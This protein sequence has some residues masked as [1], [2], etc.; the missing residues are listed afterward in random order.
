MNNN[1]E[2]LNNC[3]TFMF[4][5]KPQLLI[6]SLEPTVLIST[7]RSIFI[8]KHQIIEASLYEDELWGIFIPDG[9]ENYHHV[10]FSLLRVCQ[11]C[12]RIFWSD[13][14]DKIDF[15]TLLKGEKR[16]CED[17]LSYMYR[18]EIKEELVVT[19]AN[20]VLRDIKMDTSVLSSFVAEQRV[21]NQ[22]LEKILEKIAER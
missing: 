2:I 19:D 20:D 18:E 9:S 7:Q 12:K 22:N 21:H 1:I 8:L 5:E 3:L 10:L 13:F 15:E 11:E 4:G 16:I 17:C 14:K 6:P